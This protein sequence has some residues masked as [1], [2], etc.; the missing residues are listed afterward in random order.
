MAN[1][2][3][4][5][6]CIRCHRFFNQMIE[7]PIG[8]CL[9]CW[10]VDSCLSDLEKITINGHFDTPIIVTQGVY[11]SL[12]V[13]LDKLEAEVKRFDKDRVLFLEQKVHMLSFENERLRN[14]L[15]NF[16]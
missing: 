15:A 16:E 6:T 2:N 9:E 14:E 8:M 12:K 10:N 13:K 1:K 11:E 7:S 5:S 4:M 3:T